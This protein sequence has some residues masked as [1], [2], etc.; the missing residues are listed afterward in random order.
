M[1]I[2]QNKRFREAGNASAISFCVEPLLNAAWEGAAATNWE[3]RRH[4]ATATSSQLTFFILDG[5]NEF[6]FL[7]SH[8][9]H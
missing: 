7:K 9:Y 4:S 1:K 2:R 8:L 5:R 6:R 3:G